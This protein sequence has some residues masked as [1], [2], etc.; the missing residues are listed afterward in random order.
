[1]PQDE[2]IEELII[3]INQEFYQFKTCDVMLQNLVEPLQLLILNDRYLKN[4]PVTEGLDFSCIRDVLFRYNTRNLVEF[5]GIKENAFLYMFYYEKLGPRNAKDQKDV[6]PVKLE[7]EMKELYDEA[8][9]YVPG[10]DPS[11]YLT[12]DSS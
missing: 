5:F 12:S 10:E 11:F 4:E 6:D 3:Y 7:T 1:M 9:K 2:F 8:L